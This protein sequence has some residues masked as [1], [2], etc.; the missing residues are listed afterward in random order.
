MFDVAVS[1]PPE[2]VRES[3]KFGLHSSYERLESRTDGAQSDGNNVSVAS[4][5]FDQ[6]RT[7]DQGFDEGGIK[8]VTAM[9]YTGGVSHPSGDTPA[10]P[11]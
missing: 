3:L 11:D 4:S 10:R 9:A 2:Y 1:G 8:A 7:S 5:Y 6:G